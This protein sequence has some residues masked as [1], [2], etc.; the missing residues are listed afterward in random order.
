MITDSLRRRRILK[1]VPAKLC[2]DGSII[3]PS[4][5]FLRVPL[6]PLRLCGSNL[7]S[8][9]SHADGDKCVGHR[10]DATFFH[11]SPAFTIVP[12]GTS[13]PGPTKA[14]AAIQ[15]PSPISMGFVM[16]SKV[17]FRKSWLPVHRKARCERHTLEPITTRSRLSTS[18]SSPIHT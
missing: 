18:T 8:L 7:F 15:Q 12:A 4:P 17:C 9:A 1:L 5:L 3:N 14:H 11:T 16:R 6:R 13:A 2:G 10:R